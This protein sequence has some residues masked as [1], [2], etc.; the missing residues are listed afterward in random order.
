MSRRL[1]GK[2]TNISKSKRSYDQKLT[3]GES[4]NCIREIESVDVQYEYIGSRRWKME[5]RS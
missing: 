4:I 3:K 2:L 1:P 5:S